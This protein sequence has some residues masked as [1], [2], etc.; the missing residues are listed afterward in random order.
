VARADDG[1]LDVVAVAAVGPAAR[2]GFAAA[3]RA[4]THLDRDDVHHLRGT[5]V[6]I[7]GE[8]V[9]HNLDGELEAEVTGRGYRVLP[10]AWSL[11]VPA[12]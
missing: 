9:R 12:G 7:S 6:Q 2:A 11:L 4:G 3:L 5:R 8:P 10:G 1:R